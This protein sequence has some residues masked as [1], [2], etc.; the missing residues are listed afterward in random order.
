MSLAQIRS[1]LDEAKALGVKEYYF[2][3]GEP[4]LNRDLLI[5]FELALAQGPVSVLTNGILITPKVAAR[6]RELADASEY[7]LDIRV[8]LD[9]Y[10]AE[11]HDAIRG[12]GMFQ[13]AIKG[14]I[15]LNSAGLVPVI[16]AAEVTD[17][18]GAER[19]R[20]QFLE[21]L[22]SLGL[23]RP[24]LKILPILRMGAEVE[25]T[26]AYQEWE[27]LRGHTLSETEAARLQCNSCRMATSKG[28]YVC[29]LLIEQD[30]AR[31]GDRLADT[32][33]P[34]ELRHSACFTCHATG[35]SCRT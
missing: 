33:G 18:I 4:F 16:T 25:R 9:G 26:R 20:A 2:T 22:K 24:R 15:N 27:S 28:V 34:F 31:M 12:R 29:P 13:R 35:F 3:G 14:V 8:S 7:S 32:L 1:L 19:G 6:L 23:K 21:M 17:D 30:G 5:M 10:D 11:T